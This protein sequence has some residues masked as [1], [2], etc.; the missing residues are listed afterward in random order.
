M[1]WCRLL[2]RLVRRLVVPSVTVP[3]CAITGAEDQYAPPEL[4]S[5]FMRELPEAR[6]VRK[7]SRTAL[8]CRSSSLPTRS[9]PPSRPSPRPSVRVF[10]HEQ[11]AAI[12]STA[13]RFFPA[14]DGSQGRAG[15]HLAV[16]RQGLHGLE[17]PGATPRRGRS[18]TEPSR[19][20]ATA[21][22]VFYDGEFRNHMFRNF[23]LKVDVMTRDNSNGGIYVLTEWQEELVPE[24]GLRDPGEQQLRQGPGQDRQPLPRAGRHGQRAGQRRRVVHR[25]TSSS[26][27]TASR[28]W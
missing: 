5:A 17:S 25:D 21:S 11:P 19:P 27:A 15:L 24:E 10:A 4:V 1:Q 23:E 3:C 9:P 18:R 20:T 26:R 2:C 28:C 22:H 14:D 6:F 7:S 13:A 8:I 16:Q 12:L